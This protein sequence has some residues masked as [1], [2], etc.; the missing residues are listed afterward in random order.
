MKTQFT[1]I[2]DKAKIAKRLESGD[3]DAIDWALNEMQRLESLIR[4]FEVAFDAMDGKRNSKTFK[5]PQA[6][7]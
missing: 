7:N 4:D 5:T 2:L 3:K 6:V 1:S